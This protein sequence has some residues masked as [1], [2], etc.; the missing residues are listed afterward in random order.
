MDGGCVDLTAQ[1]IEELQEKLLIIRRFISQEKGYKN[2][3]YQGINLKDKKTPVGWLNKLLE[4]DDSEE[5]LKNCIMELEDMKTN[6]RSFTPEEFH[7]FLI[8]QDWKFLYKKYGMGTLEDV[9]KLDME[10]FWELL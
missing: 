3:Y 8:D 5:L 1:E 7:E 9:K 6:P 2:F 10:R 4:L